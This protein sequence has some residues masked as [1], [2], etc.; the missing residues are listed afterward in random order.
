MSL[1]NGISIVI[2]TYNGVKRLGP[3]LHAIFALKNLP[4]INWELIVIDNASTDD[5]SSFCIE[6]IKKNNFENKSK[7]ILESQAGCNHARM[8]GL[9]EAQYKWLL[10]CDDDNHL[11]DD[12]LV[13]A[14]KIL[15]NNDKIG[16]LGG[17]GIP[18]FESEKPEWFD[19][20]SK[21][22]AVG[23]QSNQNGKINSQKRKLYSA[24]S[25]FRKEALLFYYDKG[26]NAIMEGPKGDELTRGEDTEWCIM[27]EL[28]GYELWF[29]SSLKFN[30][31]MSDGRMTWQYYLKLKKGIAS[32][33]AK[34]EAYKPLIKLNKPNHLSFIRNY[35][36]QSVLFHFLWIQFE[37][38]KILLK[39]YYSQEDVE[40]G[41]SIHPTVAKSYRENFYKTFIHFKQL[42][43]ILK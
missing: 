10:F 4:S 31:F 36:Y 34:F 1:P 41:N 30:H 24:G 16:V 29:E 14:W 27:L 38:K 5:T 39:K 2:C 20:Y 23:P 18:L 13:N 11:F 33:K 28:I 21:S 17:Y 37:I 26:F 12:Y 32:G 3:T 22:F 40:I 42:R 9:L 15:E 25:F 7:V 8:R 43:F 19:Q 6:L 35:L